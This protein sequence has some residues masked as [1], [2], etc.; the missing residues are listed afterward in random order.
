MKNGRE[1]VR[2]IFLVLVLALFSTSHVFAASFKKGAAAYQAGD[3][4]TA[5]AEWQPLAEAGHTGALNNMALIYKKGLGVP[6]DLKKAFNYFRKSA[7][8]GFVRA[9]YN[10]AGM[11]RTG[12]GTAKNSKKAMKWMRRAAEHQMARAQYV[13]GNWYA[14]GYGVRKDKIKALTWYMIAFKN[15]KGEFNKKV[16]VKI[17]EFQS[18]LK[19]M[20][21]N[22]ALRQVDA[23]KPK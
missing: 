19:P 1:G 10:L 13:T 18:K 14:R 9:E 21:V 16:R 5:R 22:E 15:S 17:S 8:K 23:F 4:A 12:K 7:R 6:V 11:Y 3:Y 20:E 2:L